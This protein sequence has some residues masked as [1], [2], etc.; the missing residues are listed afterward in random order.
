[1]TEIVDVVIVI[2]YGP[3]GWEG[4]RGDWKIKGG[5]IYKAWD[6]RGWGFATMSKIWSFQ[7]SVFFSFTVDAM[8]YAAIID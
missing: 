2:L 6:Q 1:M 5:Q 4:V 3:K 7:V 8:G